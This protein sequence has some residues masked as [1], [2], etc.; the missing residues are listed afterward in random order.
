MSI[1]TLYANE[2]Y[3]LQVDFPEHYSMEAP[4]HKEKIWQ[5]YEEVVCCHPCF[6]YQQG[7][8]MIDGT[9]GYPSAEYGIH[10]QLLTGC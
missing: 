4:Q 7:R 6:G 2:T 8:E 10:N 9:L 1:R 5:I 3:Q